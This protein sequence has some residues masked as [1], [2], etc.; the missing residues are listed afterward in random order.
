MVVM[1]MRMVRINL[2][3]DDDPY[4]FFGGYADSSW[5]GELRGPVF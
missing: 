4:Y 5:I 2:F 3:F 1:M